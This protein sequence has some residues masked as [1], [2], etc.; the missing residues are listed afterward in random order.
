MMRIVIDTSVLVAA[1]RSRRGASFAVLAAIPSGLFQ[2]CLSV[3]LY[4]EWQQALSRPENIPQGVTPDM[5]TGFL[6]YLASQS[7]LQEIYFL[8]RPVLR[9][10]DDDMVL[11][12]AVASRSTV[13]VTH[14]V[15][16]FVGSQEFGV[17]IL[18]PSAFLR[19][20][21]GER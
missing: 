9:D 16:D 7:H 19:R 2:P 18:R 20:I 13:I 5:V 12:L 1:S 3:S 21:R 15:I 10:P 8:W 17:E 6:R 14:N 4:V 11:E